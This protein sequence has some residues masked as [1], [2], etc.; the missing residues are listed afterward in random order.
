MALDIPYRSIPDMFFARVDQTPDRHALAYPAPDGSGPVW[1]TW[2]QV[3]ERAS[4]IA[5]GLHGLGVGPEDRVAILANTRLEWILADLGITCAGGG[6]HHGLPDH[7]ARGRR[8]HPA[9]LRTRRCSSPRTRN[10][11]PRSTGADMPGLTHVVVID[12]DADPAADPP[13]LTLA[14]LERAR[15]RGARRRPGPGRAHRRGA[16]AR[17]SWPP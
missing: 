9:R 3:A 14:E 12:G 8:V 7:R 16:S 15:R 1:L 4:A 11:P 13:Q 2:A 6:D 17:T 10:R 5:A